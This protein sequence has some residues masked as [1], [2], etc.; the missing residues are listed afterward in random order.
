MAAHFEAL[1][2]VVLQ[3]LL[4]PRYTKVGFNLVSVQVY[5]ILTF[6]A[7]LC[8]EIHGCSIE[9]MPFDKSCGTS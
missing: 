7:T 8:K 5:P 4:D 1:D 3:V 9:L 2:E 6:A